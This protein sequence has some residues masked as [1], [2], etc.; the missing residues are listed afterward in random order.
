MH[1]VG[2]HLVA[3]G[4]HGRCLRRQAPAAAV[5]CDR[6]SQRPAV[7]SRPAS[8]PSPDSELSFALHQHAEEGVREDRRL[9][10]GRVTMLVAMM[11]SMPAGPASRRRRCNPACCPRRFVPWPEGS[12]PADSELPLVVP[13]PVVDVVLEPENVKGQRA[14]VGAMNIPGEPIIQIEAGQLGKI[15]LL[16]E[17]ASAF[18]MRPT[19]GAPRFRR[20]TA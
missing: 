12:Y 18:G 17:G 16:L 5:L 4:V 7:G 3:V 19:P 11:K 15:G 1:G 10:L 14:T 13:V 9:F 8:R 2:N 6:S 20:G